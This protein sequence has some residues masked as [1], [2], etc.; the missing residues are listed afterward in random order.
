[1]QNEI[2]VTVKNLSRLYAGHFAVKNLDFSVHRGEV[3][4]FLGPNGA[5][6]STTM[7]M[8]TGNLAPSEGQIFINGI[9]ILENPKA[10]KQHIGFLPEHP[11][12][13][14]ELTVDEFLRFCAQINRVPRNQ[15]TDAVNQAKARCGL[16]QVGNKLI[17]NLSKGYQQRVGIAQAIVHSPAVVVLDEPT[18]GLDPHQIREIRQLIT[19]LRGKHSIILSSHILPEVQTLCD[20]VLIINQG[21]LVLD[22][23]VSALQQLQSSSLIVAFY[24]PPELAT[25]ESI[26]SVNSVQQIDSQ[27]FRIHYE[28]SSS[29]ALMLVELSVNQHWQLFELVPETRSLEQIFLELTTTETDNDSENDPT[30]NEVAAA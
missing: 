19:E 20:R 7:N 21:V 29:P 18:V 25:L 23:S 4:G 5:G 11:P 24:Q 9:D 22:D 16:E 6:K 10:A 17:A 12:L 15:L 14:K 8:I 13:Y 27:R 28:P 1:M 3:V 2:F 26:A 30:D